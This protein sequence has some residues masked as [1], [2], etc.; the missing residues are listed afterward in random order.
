MC[1]PEKLQKEDCVGGAEQAGETE[2]G[3]DGIRKRGAR[4]DGAGL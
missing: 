2:V 3:G 1:T 4:E